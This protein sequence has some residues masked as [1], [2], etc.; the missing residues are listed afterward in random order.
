[1]EL[2]IGNSSVCYSLCFTSGRI[3]NLNLIFLDVDARWSTGNAWLG[4]AMPHG[5]A[6]GVLFIERF[7]GCMNLI[8]HSELSMQS[9]VLKSKK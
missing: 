2:Y 5:G 8:Y 7:K 3:T 9:I 4:G 6:L 1:M